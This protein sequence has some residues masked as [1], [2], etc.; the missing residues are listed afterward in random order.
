MAAMTDYLELKL[1]DHI[2]G[3]AS[4]TAPSAVYLGLAVGD[5]T[6]TGTGQAELSGGGY[7][8][9]QAT[10][11]S[12]ANGQITNSAAIEFPEATTSLGTVSHWGLFD[13]AT[14]GNMLLNGAFDSAKLIEAQDILR[15]S[16]GSLTLTA[17]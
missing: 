11:G 4:Y 14:G 6:D 16:A 15:I 7:A 10:F 3:V 13:A 12:A 8:R 1:L 9:T 2:T 17:A 5:F